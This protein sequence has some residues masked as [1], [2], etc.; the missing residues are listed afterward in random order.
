MA[1]RVSSRGARFLAATEQLDNGT[2]VV[3]VMGEVDL[4]TAPALERTLRGVA[5]NR[6]GEVIVDLSGCR[7]L[8]SSGL[9]ALIATRS[10]L[11]RSKR[12]LALVLPN[13][14]VLRIFQ[15]TGLDELF[16]TYPSLGA[17]AGVNGDADG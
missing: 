16:E 5:E 11:E 8:D 3:S 14:S 2:P 7:F 10:R 9:R 6:T 12:P 17:A 15:I 13:A 1:A 4:A